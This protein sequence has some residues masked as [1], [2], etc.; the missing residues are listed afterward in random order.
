LIFLIS[1]HTA[2]TS[3][4][5]P[6]LGLSEKLVLGENSDADDFW[7][8]FRLGWKSSSVDQPLGNL[9]DKTLVEVL[10]H[11]LLNQRFLYFFRSPI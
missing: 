6:E 11:F 7:L 2:D 8:W 1:K 10:W 4:I 9:H 5:L 3:G